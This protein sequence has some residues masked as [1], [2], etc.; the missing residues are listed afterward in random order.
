MATEV[1]TD[2]KTGAKSLLIRQSVFLFGLSMIAVLWMGLAWKLQAGRHALEYGLARD[3]ENLAHAFEESVLRTMQQV[4]LRLQFLRNRVAQSPETA[5]W[6]SLISSVPLDDEIA[7]QLS[8]VDAKGL[9]VSSTLDP[10]PTKPVDLSDR[11]HIRVHLKGGGDDLFISR[12]LLGRVSKQWSLNITRSMR[13]PDG[14][15][16]GI[17]VASMSPLFITKFTENIR[18][19]ARGGFMLVGVD[20]HVRASSMPLDLGGASLQGTDL[21]RA[22]ANGTEGHFKGALFDSRHAVVAWRKVR[23]LPLYVLVSIDRAD[24]GAGLS[25]TEAIEMGAALAVTLLIALATTLIVR[26]QYGVHVAREQLQ[27]TARQVEAKSRE[28]E[29]M[30]DSITQGIVMVDRRGGLLVA[31][32]RALE[33]LGHANFQS[34]VAG[35]RPLLDECKV[36]LR[37]STPRDHT[38]T[39]KRAFGRDEERIIEFAESR[40]ADGNVVL[41]LT[42][43]TLVRRRQ[44]E[45]E[46]ASHAADAA[47]RA[48]SQFLSTMSHEMRTPL[49]GMIGALD[50]L[51]KTGLE[52][53]Q[54]QFVETALQSGEA[55]LVHINDVLDFSK[56]E[57]GKLVL[58][59]APF[60]LGHLVDSVLK[61][62]APQAEPRNNALV[63]EIGEGTPHYVVG[64]AIRVRQ[65]LL[66]LVGNA[67]KFTRNGRI[68]VGVKPV[69][70][71]TEVPELLVS[72]ADTGQ[73]IPQDRLGHLFQEFSMVDA[74]Y[75]RKEGGTGLGLAICKRLVEAMGGEIGVDSKLGEGSCFWFRVPLPRAAELPVD[76]KAADPSDAATSS[77]DVLLVD[78]NLTNQMVASRMLVSA[79][80]TVTTAS[81]GLEALHAATAKRYD[82]I[83][84][85]VSMPE[86]DGIEAT[87]RIRK[88]AEPFA[89]VPIIALTA[90]AIAGD[91]ERFIAAGMNDY[92]TKPIRRATI[93]TRLA[94]LAGE[95]H[96]KGT[97]AVPPAAPAPATSRTEPSLVDLGELQRLAQETAPEV[98]PLVV[99][100]FIT[101]ARGRLEEIKAAHAAADTEA[102]DKAAHALAGACASVGALSLRSAA[103]EIELMCR[104]NGDAARGEAGGLVPRLAPMLDET[105]AALTK[106]V[107]TIGTNSAAVSAAA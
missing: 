59:P 96:R 56:M 51:A 76:D 2:S 88:L 85:D 63:R 44:T 98:V 97:A 6:K 65:I 24:A 22:F 58:E 25:Q 53:E 45:L 71:T 81:D 72:I 21:F 55:L 39:F 77:L 36:D 17:G 40:M 29:G 43:V 32:R 34:L 9:L 78:D 86:M 57:A 64:D 23:S 84:M 91:R 60:N 67:V 10:E 107:E 31:N 47:N 101:E 49:N 48:K 7:F 19:G 83:L 106:A 18:I 89:S 105:T 14:Q 20:G 54:R 15:V 73:G 70:G 94:R 38:G 5:T 52:P 82:V 37:S 79:G 1:P 11:E 46:M 35:I 90:N 80:H 4:D 61:I 28:L 103:K 75:T 69:G 12:P 62:V 41:T 26:S 68:T 50:L 13:S 3:T 30:L 102:L 74:S 95:L 87:K 104:S 8:L 93:E 100:Q 99:E 92:L 16:V 66:N 27:A 42:D 33:L